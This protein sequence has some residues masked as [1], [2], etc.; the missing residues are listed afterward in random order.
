MKRMPDGQEV[1]ALP[2]Y[3]SMPFAA[4]LQALR[5]PQKDEITY[6]QSQN[7]RHASATHAHHTNAEMKH[8]LQ[9]WRSDD[10]EEQEC[11]CTILYWYICVGHVHTLRD[12]CAVTQCH[13]ISA[14]GAVP[15]SLLM[16]A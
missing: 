14:A 12:Q 2:A 5:M 15:N 1:F 4:F 8:P 10:A 11:N 7:N 6:A 13:L 16:Q 9:L 3:Q